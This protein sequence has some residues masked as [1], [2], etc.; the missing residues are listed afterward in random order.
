M[1]TAGH[2]ASTAPL[3]SVVLSFRNEQEV[4]PRLIERLTL[5]LG[6]AGVRHELIFVNDASSDGSREPSSRMRGYATPASSSSTCP[7][8]SA[9]PSA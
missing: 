6:E 1:T 4:L 5:A 7:A 2:A 8:A 9:S 3:V